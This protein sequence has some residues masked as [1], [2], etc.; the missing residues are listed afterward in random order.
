MVQTIQ[1]I[2]SQ[3]TQSSPPKEDAFAKLVGH[4]GK[5]QFLIFAAVFMVKLSSGWVQM[6]I[7][8]LTPNI[9]FWCVEFNNSTDLEQSLLLEDRNYPLKNSSEEVNNSTCY[10]DCLKYEYDTG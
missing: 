9:T 7:L 5:W 4:F 10:K 8:F 2:L 1:Q 6:A 3:T